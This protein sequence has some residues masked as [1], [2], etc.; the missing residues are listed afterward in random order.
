MTVRSSSVILACAVVLSATSPV[1][2]QSEPTGNKKKALEMFD[3]GKVQYDLGRWEQAADLWKQAYE[4]FSAPEFLFNI[5]QAYRHKG[6]CQNGPFFYRR[7]L[8]ARPNAKNRREVE[9]Y[10]E[11]L[12]AAC[13]AKQSA[14]G[15]AAGGER[16]RGGGAVEGGAGTGGTGTGGAGGPE[17]SEPTD[18]GREPGA[19]EVA[20]SEGG[21]DIDE[22]EGQEIEERAELPPYRPQILA[23]RVSVGPSFPSLGTL[24]VGTLVSL[25]AGIS[26]PISLGPILLEPGALVTYSPVPW[27]VQQSEA[28][29]TAGLTGL[30]ANLG[31]GYEFI[32]SLAGRAD[33]GV[34]ALVFSG[35]TEDGNPFLDMNDFADGAIAMF[36]VRAALGVEYAITRNLLIQAQPVVFSYSPSRPLRED[37]DSITR[38]EMLVGAG[39]RM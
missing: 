28:E 37:I 7:Y 34:G 6:D 12:E 23:V 26:H 19:R 27:E 15:D 9:G 2:A 33:V 17:D 35:L 25:T 39:Y 5:A 30:L 3:R 16:G 38:F 8:A 14:G 4:T 11:D 10:I 31:A 21:D 29:G 24:D 18:G 20:A 22:A 13:K 36:H 1:L 32:P